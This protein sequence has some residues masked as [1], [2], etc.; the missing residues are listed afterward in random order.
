LIEFAEEVTKMRGKRRI[1]AA[2]KIRGVAELFEVD[3]F[4]DGSRFSMVS[5]SW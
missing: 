1:A 5:V 4:G 3:E 2:L